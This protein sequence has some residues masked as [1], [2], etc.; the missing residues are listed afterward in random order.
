MISFISTFPP[1]ICG[2]GTYTKYI[3]EH[4]S[5]RHWRVISFDL[6]NFS[7]SKEPLSPKLTSQVDYCLSFPCPLLPSI[8]KNDLLWF[9]HSFGVWGNVNDHFLSLLRE[10]KRRGNKVIAS[11]H[12]IHFETEETPWGMRRNE[13]QLLRETLPLVDA[14]TVF[15]DGAHRAVV[16]AF[17][18]FD[19]KIMVLRHGVH[20]YPKIDPQQARKRVLSYLINEAAIPSFQKKELKVAEALF[21]SKNSI[22]IGNYGF[23]T[24]FKAPLQLFELGRLVQERLPEHRVVTLFAGII[25]R[26]NDGSLHKGI[27]IL[28]ALRSSHDGKYN[29]FFEVYVPEDIF[30]IAFRALDFAVFWCHNATQSGRLA[31]AQG[32]GVFITGRDCEGIGE[33]LKLSGLPAAE[34]LSELAE[35]IA[36]VVLEPGMKKEL[37]NQSWQYAQHHSFAMQAKKHLLIEKLLARGMDLPP[38]DAGETLQT[39]GKKSERVYNSTHLGQNYHETPQSAFLKRKPNHPIDPQHRK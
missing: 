6:N 11:F 22:L 27:P 19:H 39:R 21:Y 16:N 5:K 38:L 25:Q 33:T 8:S 7:T 9:Q 30:P 13:E 10:A 17:P 2:I 4:I 31:H 1:I 28:E 34:S 12:T 3:T 14:L 23:I 26:T 37:E 35:I 20:L 32:T 24:S 15:T 29:F 36:E 18:E